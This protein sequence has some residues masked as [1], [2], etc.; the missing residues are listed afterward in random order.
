M[1]SGALP[2]FAFVL[3]FV[4]AGSGSA[5]TLAILTS[6]R[7]ARAARAAFAS[8]PVRG[9]TSVDDTSSVGS[10]CASSVTLVP[11]ATRRLVSLS[12]AAS[13]AVFGSGTVGGTYPRKPALQTAHVAHNALVHVHY[14]VFRQSSLA[15]PAARYLEGN[16]APRPRSR[17][18]LC[19]GRLELDQPV[20]QGIRCGHL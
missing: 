12:Q 8:A 5:L 9:N 6:R 2:A 18:S 7:L 11:G 4:L 13:A 3:A 19:K 1:T 16:G 17:I 14:E 15:C 10:A 20:L